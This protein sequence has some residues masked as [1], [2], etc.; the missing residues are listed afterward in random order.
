MGGFLQVDLFSYDSRF[1]ASPLVE[2]CFLPFYPSLQSALTWRLLLNRLSIEDSLCRVRFHLA[3]QCS[4]YG[5]SSE[6]SNHLFIRCP[7]AAALWEAIFSAFQWRISADTWSSL[8]SQAM[9]VSFSNQV[10]DFKFTL[11]LVWHA[12]FDA[13]LLEIGC[14]RNCVDDLLILHWFDIRGCPVR[15]FVIRSVIW[16]PLPLGWT[17]VNTDGAALS[18]PGVRGCGG[19]F[20]NCRAF[21]NGCFVVPLDHVFMFEAELRAASMTINFAWQNR[22]HRIWLESDSSYVIR[23]FYSRSE[24]VPWR[25]R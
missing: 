3:F 10:M 16:S 4:V 2:R 23:M 21:V 22:W 8:L 12:V 9:S 5:V 1:S 19:V 7:L 15:A 14:M 18:S 6:S 24:Q 11:S 25:I 13:N 20:R 17:K